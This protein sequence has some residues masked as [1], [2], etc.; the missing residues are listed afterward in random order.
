MTTCCVDEPNREGP[1]VSAGRSDDGGRWFAGVLARLL[2]HRARRAAPVRSAASTASV[3]TA[4]RMR[5][6][7]FERR[8]SGLGD[9]LGGRVYPL[10]PTPRL[11]RSR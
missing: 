7:D 8:G 2:A 4:R 9:L 6:E 11:P 1:L 10:M 5:Y 3:P